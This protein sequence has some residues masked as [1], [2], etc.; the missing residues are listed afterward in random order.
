MLTLMTSTRASA[1]RSTYRIDSTRRTCRLATHFVERGVHEHIR[2]DNGPE[3]TA[4]AVREWLA[5]VA[6]FGARAFAHS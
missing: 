6:V 5:K 4:T 2:S 1:C 3:F